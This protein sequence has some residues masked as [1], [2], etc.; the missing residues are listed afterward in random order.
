MHDKGSLRVLEADGGDRQEW[1]ALLE[2]WAGREVFSHPDYLTLFA[3]PGERPMCAVYDGAGTRVIH[4]FLLR[5][6]RAT[7]FWGQGR[8][9]V[10]DIVSPPYG[11]GGP[12]VEGT[13]TDRSALTAAFF[14]EYERWAWSQKVASEYVIFSPKEEGAPSYPGEV[15]SRPIVVRTL[16]LAPED[17]LRDYKSTVPRC[18]RAAQRAGVCVVQDPTGQRRQDFLDVYE[19]TMRRRNADASYDLTPAFLERLNRTLSGYFMYFFALLDDRVVAADLLLLSA[20]SIFFFRGG[21]LAEAFWARPTHLL[22]HHVFLWGREQGKRCLL[23][24]GGMDV[25][26]S[27]YRFKL[28][29]APRGGRP[30]RFGK[31]ILD[32]SSYDRLLAARRLYERSHGGEWTP[33]PS[34]F[35]AYRAPTVPS[36]AV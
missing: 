13:A 24:G 33:R 27:L 20:D 26:D 22:W 12:F 5:D 1:L 15:G 23:L 8:E 25:D 30:L 18:I 35:P 21:T 32:A 4:P 31:W 14:R 2:S 17:I 3:G 16:D 10:Y 28:S 9:E 34:Y 6:L 36:N 7:A 11:Y 29:F 19:D